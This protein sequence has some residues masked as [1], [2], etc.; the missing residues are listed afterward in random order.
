[1]RDESHHARICPSVFAAVIAVVIAVAGSEIAVGIVVL[2]MLV[3]V[4][5]VRQML[6]EIAPV[7]AAP[8]P[9]LALDIDRIKWSPCVGILGRVHSNAPS[10]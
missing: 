6:D 1:M 4:V 2:T 8:G 5:L 3:D 7:V 9:H 10:W